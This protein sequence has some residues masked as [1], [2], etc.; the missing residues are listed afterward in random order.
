MACD[1]LIADS[2]PLYSKGLATV[3]NDAGCTKV[4]VLSNREDVLEATA[5]EDPEVLIV[6]ENLRD[7]KGCEI[8]RELREAGDERPVILLSEQGPSAQK[9]S[10]IEL[11]INGLIGKD[12]RP[13]EMRECFSEVRRGG[14][15]IDRNHLQSALE[16]A[17]GTKSVAHRDLGLTPREHQVLHLISLDRSNKEIAERLGIAASTIK[18]HLHNIYRKLG[19]GNRR[20][21]NRLIRRSGSNRTIA[22]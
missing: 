15:W 8:F 21:L 12:V 22:K 3:L 4:T 1:V 5:A 13:E 18:V 16:V 10:A 7:R 2:H 11:G 20:E 17:L 6:S 14:R 9:I 19:L